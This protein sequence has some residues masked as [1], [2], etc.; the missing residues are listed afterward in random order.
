EKDLIDFCRENIA[1]YKKPRSVDFVNDLPKSNYGKIL[2]RELRDQY[3]Q[4]Q[5]R[6]M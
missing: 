4:D 2:K 5:K 6:N 3:W 1:G